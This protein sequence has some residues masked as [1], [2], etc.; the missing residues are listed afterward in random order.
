M[1]DSTAGLF[2]FERDEFSDLNWIPLVIRY[3][4]D[5]CGLK[6]SLSAWQKL[7]FAERARLLELPFGDSEEVQAWI[8]VLNSS[9]AIQGG[10]PPVSMPRWEEPKEPPS[11]VKERLEGPL[12]W[13][14]LSPLQRYALCK[15]AAS[16]TPDRYFPKAL[17]EFSIKSPN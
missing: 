3:R 8:S 11:A 10:G 7:P 16:K 14:L 2:A 15:L 12:N 13:D 9:L 17:R 5:S 4:L 6:L 1:S